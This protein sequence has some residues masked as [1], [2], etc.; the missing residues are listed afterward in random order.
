MPLQPTLGD[1]MFIRKRL[2][3]ANV[4]AT[5]ALLFA[6]SGGALAASKYLI[7]STKQIS[8]KVVK[9]LK[10][11]AGPAGATGKEGALGKEGPPG[12]D[13]AE[14]KAGEPGT[15]RA[16]AFINTAGEVS[17]AKGITQANVTLAGG[18]LY[19]IHGLS[20]T[21]ENVI[22]SVTFPESND[23]IASGNVGQQGA[24]PTGTQASIATYN[25]SGSVVR[26]DVEVLIN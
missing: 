23:L 12:K 19:C 22:T 15:A 3:Y 4:V 18:S 16:Y 2:T 7:T 21:P 14:G 10:G 9:Q 8:P 25:T 20:F 6:M 11:K 26:G 24:C 5:L 17:H 1:G 13:G